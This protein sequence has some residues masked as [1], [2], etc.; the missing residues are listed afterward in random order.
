[1]RVLNECMEAETTPVKRVMSTELFRIAPDATAQTAAETLLTQGIG[2]LLVVDRDGEL[3]GIVTSTDLIEVVSGEGSP[4]E[5]TVREHMTTDVVTIGATDS[6]HD[7]AVEMI[8]GDIQH[9]PVTGD[10]SDIVGM[11]SA[12]DITTQMTY[13]GSSGTD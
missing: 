6:V 12:T 5:S 10:E 2:S 3:A 9:L 13:M 1:M 11:A 4:T 8:R 7:A